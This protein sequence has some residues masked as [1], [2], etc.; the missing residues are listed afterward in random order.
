MKLSILD[1]QIDNLAKPELLQKIEQFLDSDKQ[2]HIVTPNPEF[3][4][5]A[6]KDQDFKNIL[7][8]ADLAIPDGFGLKIA[9]RLLNHQKLQR[10]TGV[11]T[12]YDICAI[13]QA[14]NKS[15]YFFGAGEGIAKK[16][17]NALKKRFPNLKIA[18]AESGGSINLPITSYQL[19]V[20]SDN[21][22]G[23]NDDKNIDI[24]KKTNPDILFIALGQ[25]KQEKWL[26][27]NLSKLPSVRLAMGVGG[28]FDYISGKTPRAPKFLR[29]LG[30]EWL[31]RLVLQPKRI[32]R[33]WNAVAVFM[34]LVFKKKLTKLIH[35]I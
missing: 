6:G 23:L 33:I 3:L 35:I 21:D 28:S 18:G 34:W 10:H 26:A 14:K 2:S 4:V 30:L 19:L 16:S 27:Q 29:F 9:A 5:A 12:I 1:I 17:A 25:V 22:N 20:T 32:K 7:N 24:I 8:Q 31:F 13:A 15:V 11:D